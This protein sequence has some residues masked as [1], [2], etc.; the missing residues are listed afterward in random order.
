MATTLNVKQ[1]NAMQAER[2][3]DF[4]AKLDRKG[5]TDN[6][7]KKMCNNYFPRVNKNYGFVTF[8][9]RTRSTTISWHKRKPY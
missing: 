4:L 1:Y 5:L 9:D 8:D 6:D 3:K 2:E 7:I